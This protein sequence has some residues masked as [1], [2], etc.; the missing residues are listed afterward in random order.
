VYT[1][2]PFFYCSD[3]YQSLFP[4]FSPHIGIARIDRYMSPIQL[5]FKFHFFCFSLGQ[6]PEASVGGVPPPM[7]KYPIDVPAHQ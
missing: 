1:Q 7:E 6:R 4:A 3:A 5:F 2:T